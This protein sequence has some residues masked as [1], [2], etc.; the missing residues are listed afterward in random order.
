MRIKLQGINLLEEFG[1]ILT[2][3]LMDY[4][5]KIGL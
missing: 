1:L 4:N 5:P 2:Y 3:C